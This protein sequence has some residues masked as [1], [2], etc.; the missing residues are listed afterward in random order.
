MSFITWKTKG[1]FDKIENF[2]KRMSEEE[3]YILAIDALCKEGVEQ[4]RAVTPKKTGKASRS[5]SYEYEIGAHSTKVYWTN[6]DVTPA[7]TP[8][9][10]LIQHGHG[11]GTGGYVQ[12]N[13]FINPVMKAVFN[14]IAERIWEEVVK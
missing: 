10:L 6:S 9:V 1:D 5:W 8:I 3:N 14:S 4:L 13:D 11:T 2:C 12:P 7:G